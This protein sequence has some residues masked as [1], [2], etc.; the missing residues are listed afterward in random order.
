MG[1]K[2]YYAV[3]AGATASPT[4]APSGSSSPRDDRTGRASLASVSCD[5]A[6]ANYVD[7]AAAGLRCYVEMARGFIAIRG[8]S[9]DSHSSRTQGTVWAVVWSAARGRCARCCVSVPCLSPV[10]VRSRLGTVSAR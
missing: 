9:R 7:A 2:R 10:L 4:I 8:H 6:Q 5:C 1:T 3:L